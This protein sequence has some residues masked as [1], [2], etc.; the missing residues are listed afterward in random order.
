MSR[1]PLVVKVGGSLYDLPDLATRLRVWSHQHM[2]ANTLLIPGGGRLADAIRDLDRLH[3]LGEEA[4]H[5]LALA[6]LSVNA[7]FLARLLPG[8][9]VLP[10]LPEDRD[11]S[12]PFIL[13]PLPFFEHDEDQ[14]GALPHLWQ[15]TSD[16]LAVRVAIRASARELVLLKS[17]SWQGTDDWAKAAWNGVVD[18]FFERAMEAAAGLQVH[19]INLRG[20]G[21]VSGEWVSEW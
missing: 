4:S 7:R 14:P 6:A 11:G 21:Y 2:H 18:P 8:P 3:H 15:V 9:R 12:G 17:I 5:W 20:S 13:D 16:S 10:R 19:I 1:S